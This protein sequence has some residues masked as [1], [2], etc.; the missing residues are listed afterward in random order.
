M[1]KNLDIRERERE[2]LELVVES[3]I[4]ESKPISSSHLCS[5]YHLPYSSATVRNVMVGLEQK[6]LLSHPHTSSGRVPTTFAFKQYAEH[7]QDSG[8]IKDYPVTLGTHAQSASDLQTGISCALDAL[9]EG[10][11]YT[12]LVA[13]SGKDERFLFR[14][15]RFI[16]EQPEFEDITRLKNLFYALEVQISQLQELLFHYLDERVTILVGDEIGF[17]EIADCSLMVSGSKEKHCSFALGV[18]GP[19]RMNYSKAACCL[20]SVKNELKRL[21]EVLDE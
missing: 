11:G 18:L 6:G 16:L 4:E 2:I 21:I 9:A 20:Y 5:R 10:S 3:Y 17:K 8:D 13:I 1:A 14:G 15:S 7:L 19:V 12:S